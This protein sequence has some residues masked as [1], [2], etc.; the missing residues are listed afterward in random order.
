MIH[1]QREMMIFFE[2][3][4]DIWMCCVFI[5]ILPEG[6]KMTKGYDPKVA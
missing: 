2:Y 1:E 4:M 6:T 3:L 5:S